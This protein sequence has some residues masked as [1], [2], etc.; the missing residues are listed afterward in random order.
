MNN[1]NFFAAVVSVFL[2][3]SLLIASFFAIRTR[4]EDDKSRINKRLITINC[5]IGAYLCIN[6]TLQIQ[7]NPTIDI[8]NLYL[9]DILGSVIGLWFLGM[10][11]AAIPAVISSNIAMIVCK[12]TSR[13][14]DIPGFDGAMTSGILSMY[15]AMS[16]GVLLHLLGIKGEYFPFTW[17]P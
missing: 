10:V 14:S 11:P 5:L 2:F 8:S 9:E 17:L 3:I 12:D 6:T 13:K 15:V 4:L 16:Y 7:P 1:E